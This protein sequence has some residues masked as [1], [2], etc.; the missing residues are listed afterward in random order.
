MQTTTTIIVRNVKYTFADKKML[1]AEVS[2]V[3]ITKIIFFAMLDFGMP[4]CP[5]GWVGQAC[6]LRDATDKI[7]AVVPI[8]V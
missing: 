4:T 1:D 6:I 5:K 7:S 2:Y 3:H 8:R